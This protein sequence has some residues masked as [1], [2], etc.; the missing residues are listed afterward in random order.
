M[1]L[2]YRCNLVACFVEFRAALAKTNGYVYLAPK[3]ALWF[4]VKRQLESTDL[5]PTTTTVALLLFARLEASNQA[6]EGSRS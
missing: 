5:A 3:D 2:T 6:Q 4:L 1:V